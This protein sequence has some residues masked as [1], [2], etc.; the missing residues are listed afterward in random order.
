M[1]VIPGIEHEHAAEI[2]RVTTDQQW[3]GPV[4]RRDPGAKGGAEVGQVINRN[5]VALQAAT[6]HRQEVHQVR[7]RI[8]RHRDA[9]AL[10]QQRGDAFPPTPQWRLPIEALMRAEARQ[11]KGAAE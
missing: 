5:P 4:A 10:R 8:S 6:Q 1:A 7:A 9:P 3:A 2:A 11:A